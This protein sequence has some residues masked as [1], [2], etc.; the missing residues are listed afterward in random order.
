MG[1]D[2]TAAGR[3]PGTV[4][5]VAGERPVRLFRGA[6]GL[7]PVRDRLESGGGLAD[8]PLPRG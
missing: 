6:H 8:P 4:R 5:K 7:G 3:A 1:K 2:G